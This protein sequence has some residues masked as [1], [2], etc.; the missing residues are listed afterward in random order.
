MSTAALGVQWAA[1]REVVCTFLSRGIPDMVLERERGY[2]SFLATA[3]LRR[4]AKFMHSRGAS[5][6][7][8]SI[9]PVCAL[10]IRQKR[11]LWEESEFSET[12]ECSIHSYFIRQ[13]LTK[14]QP[15]AYNSFK[16]PFCSCNYN[17]QDAYRHE[18]WERKH[19]KA[20]QL[21]VGAD[22]FRCVECYLGGKNYKNYEYLCP[23]KNVIY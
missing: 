8:G 15:C 5:W 13:T 9:V 19:L 4:S 20:E 21:I 1:A 11:F 2:H 3:H 17:C 12:T 16:Q 14:R 6:L 22:R 7:L 18:A 10:V 23:F